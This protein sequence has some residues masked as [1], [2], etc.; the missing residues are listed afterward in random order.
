MA[1]LH[2]T[3]ADDGHP[4]E[5]ATVS[6]GVIAGTAKTV[7]VWRSTSGCSAGASGRRPSGRCRRTD[8]VAAALREM[9]V[10]FVRVIVSTG[11]TGFA[12]RLTPEGMRA[13]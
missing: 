1:D 9:A 10:G 11:G 13:R 3:D 7:L 5:G 2:T 4:G 8:S 12:T 6:D